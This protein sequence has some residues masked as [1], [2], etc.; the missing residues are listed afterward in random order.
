M[1]KVNLDNINYIGADIVEKLILSNVVNNSEKT[2]LKF[3]VMNLMNE[4]LP[5]SDL[6]FVRDCF[7]H[8]SYE[9]IY[10]CINNI[11]SSGC[12]YLLTTT[13]T[14]RNYNIDIETGDWRPLNLNRK[15]FDFP[16]PLLIIN[17]NCTEGRGNFKDKCMALWEIDNI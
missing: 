12:K 9:D 5:K 13:F 6:L 7:V 14:N 4:P 17:E 3:Q 11:K 10:S 1:Q 16:Q 2:N 8:L 15:P